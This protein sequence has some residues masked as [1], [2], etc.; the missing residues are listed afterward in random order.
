MKGHRREEASDGTERE[1]ERER[2]EGPATKG[3]DERGG[4]K[5]QP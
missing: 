4:E 1:K 5:M 3:G 2:Q